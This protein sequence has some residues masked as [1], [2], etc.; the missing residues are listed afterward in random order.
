M[1]L[2][3][4]K[5]KSEAEA[6]LKDTDERKRLH[7]HMT[8]FLKS[9]E[10]KAGYDAADPS[11]KREFFKRFCGNRMATMQ[12]KSLS[13][14]HKVIS[15]KGKSKDWEWKTEEEI[16]QPGGKGANWF[17]AMLALYNKGDTV[18]GF[19]E[20]QK[21]GLGHWLTEY[22]VWKD[23]VFTFCLYVNMNI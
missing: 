21:Q 15:N 2:C 10:Q 3:T 5:Q 7:N 4:D 1:P 22:K 9:K 13:T 6:I 18:N 8:T 19:K 12:E 20:I 23:S 17:A 16:S 11:F 14:G